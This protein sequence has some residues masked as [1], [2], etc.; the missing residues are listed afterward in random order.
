MLRKLLDIYLICWLYKF[1]RA[2]TI[3]W[4]F[5]TG[6]CA[7]NLMTLHTCIIRTINLS[8]KTNIFF[9]KYRLR[10]FY[11]TPTDCVKNPEVLTYSNLYFHCHGN[12]IFL[13]SVTPLCFIL[14]VTFIFL[15][16]SNVLIVCIEILIFKLEC[17]FAVQ[18]SVTPADAKKNFQ[19][20]QP[21]LEALP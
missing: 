19:L 6:C 12:Y 17:A 21:Q 1:F 3:R 8:R 15:A 10:D 14:K 20:F 11:V 13:H 18:N 5:N 16:L 2:V 7:A 9:L 4:W